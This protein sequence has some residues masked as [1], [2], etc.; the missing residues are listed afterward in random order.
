MTG[1]PLAALRAGTHVQHEALEGSGWLEHA[2]ADRDAYGDHLLRVATFVR[3]AECALA[4][5]DDELRAGGFAPAERRKNG[6]VCEELSALGLDAPAADGGAAF[7]ALS[8]FS[9]AVGCL[10]VLEGSTLGGVLI[11]RV[12]RE[13]LDWESTFYGG[14]G[15]RTAEMWRAFA[16]A[17]NACA[18]TLNVTTLVPAAQATFEAY[19]ARITRVYA[20]GVPLTA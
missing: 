10:Y 11:A 15:R 14:Y 9:A 5:F 1:D 16:S 2:V 17:A 8:D 6:R 13:R 7:P 12:V 18:A 20:S 19:G 3:D 4:P